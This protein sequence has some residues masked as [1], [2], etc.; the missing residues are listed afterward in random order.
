MTA[1]VHDVDHGEP[2]PATDLEVVE[3]VARGDLDRARALF[4]VGVFVGDDRQPSADQRQDGAFADQV[5][6]ARVVGVHGDAGVAEHGLRPGR[7]DRDVAAGLAFNRVADVPELAVDLLLLDLEIGHRGLQLAI[8]VDQSLVLVDQAGAV[9][10]DEHL[11]H[12]RRQAFVHGEAFARPVRRGAQAMELLADLAARAL[13]PGPH[14]LDELLAPEIAA[15]DAFFRQLALDH[16]LGG[17]AGVVAARLPQHGAAEHAVEP[18]QR[19]LDGVVEGMA[20]VQAAGD[21]RRR[22]DDAVGPRRRIIDR[23]EMAA[24]LPQPVELGLDLGRPVGLVQHR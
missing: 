1:R 3:V 23:R 15:R 16:H 18:D 10:V 19:I 12:R 2:V 5:L 11:A 9:Q 6:I 4:R 13:L 7:R 24:L 20:H 22:D 8:P 21:V 17:D 14:P